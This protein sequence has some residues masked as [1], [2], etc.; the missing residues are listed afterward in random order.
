[1]T[2]ISTKILGM[3][4][5]LIFTVIITCGF[6]FADDNS[7]SN[8]NYGI[9]EPANYTYYSMMINQS[10]DSQSYIY[11]GENNQHYFAS[12][13]IPLMKGDSL[14]L[15][16]STDA[17]ATYQAVDMTGASLLLAGNNSTETGEQI[18]NHTI[19][20]LTLVNSSNY[21]GYVTASE[22]TWLCLV[23]WPND[24]A[25]SPSGNIKAIRYTQSNQNIGPGLNTTEFLNYCN[26]LAEQQYESESSQGDDLSWVPNTDQI[27]TDGITDDP[28][29]N[30]AIDWVPDMSVPDY[31]DVSQNDGFDSWGPIV[32][33][34]S[35]SMPDSINSSNTDMVLPSFSSSTN[36]TGNITELAGKYILP[37]DDIVN[38][39]N[40]DAN[41][42][43]NRWSNAVTTGNG[44][45][46][47]DE[48]H[49][50]IMP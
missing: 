9:I 15:N 37:S 32:P 36:F 27:S 21:D 8:E 46:V 31:S 13:Y 35:Y 40:D 43:Y 12:Y 2:K 23:V 42:A 45:G 10:L 28:F 26:E 22:D 34:I 33:N 41:N 4:L 48:Y 44:Y 19:W 5:F 39:M 20:N 6:A 47:S 17:N 49:L 16:L 1:M 18:L 29:N 50:D 25:N 30:E 24:P 14:Y 11:A 7:Q 3:A 38:K